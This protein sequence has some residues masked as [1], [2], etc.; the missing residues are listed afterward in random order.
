MAVV[1]IQRASTLKDLKEFSLVRVPREAD[2]LAKQYA[3]GD[4]PRA[5]LT[6]ELVAPEA[7][8]MQQIAKEKRPLATTLSIVASIAS[9]LLLAF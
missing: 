7:S 3:I 2:R 9:F 1:E 6:A 4:K 8:P 5:T